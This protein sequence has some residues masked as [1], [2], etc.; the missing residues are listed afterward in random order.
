[1]VFDAW[2][3]EAWGMNIQNFKT[4][5]NCRKLF[6]FLRFSFNFRQ[7]SCTCTVIWKMNWCNNGWIHIPRTLF[8]SLKHLIHFSVQRLFSLFRYHRYFRPQNY[9]VQI[10][11]WVE[12]HRWIAFPSSS[13]SK[14]DSYRVFQFLNNI[15]IL[16]MATVQ[17]SFIF[18]WNQLMENQIQFSMLWKKCEVSFM[19]TENHYRYLSFKKNCNW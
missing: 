5:R 7:S 6:S 8:N 11:G 13:E 4:D 10:G 19:D 16:E 15:K 18:N 1:M 12:E 9:V 17:P 14:D 2:S 3:L